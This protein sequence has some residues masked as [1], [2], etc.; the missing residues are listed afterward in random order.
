MK[1]FLPFGYIAS[2]V[3]RLW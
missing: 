1:K 2:Y 3:C